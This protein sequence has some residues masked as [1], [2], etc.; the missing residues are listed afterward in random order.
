MACLPGA[1][2]RVVQVDRDGDVLIQFNNNQAVRWIQK[3]DF[4]KMMAETKLK[5]TEPTNTASHQVLL[6]GLD[7]SKMCE[8]QIWSV[9]EQSQF[10]D[11][12]LD[13]FLQG[14]SV[15]LVFPTGTTAQ[16][17]VKCFNGRSIDKTKIT[18]TYLLAPAG[19]MKQMQKQATP[20]STDRSERTE[21]PGRS[22]NI[23]GQ[24]CGDAHPVKNMPIGH[25]TPLPRC[26]M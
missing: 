16:E 12:V 5:N 2:F 18:A 14:T 13:L 26:R 7:F 21:N 25:R 17:G 10:A 19:K 8:A 22:A 23:C 24:M 1:G 11:V 4:V 6:D 20:W 9:L 15:V 3:K